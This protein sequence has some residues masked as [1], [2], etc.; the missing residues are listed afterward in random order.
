M[1]F[2]ALEA[3]LR[4]LERVVDPNGAR[5]VSRH[6]S[7]QLRVAH[8]AASVRSWPQRRRVSIFHK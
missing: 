1:V 8:Y 5:R 4:A 7:Q 6:R 2:R 3:D